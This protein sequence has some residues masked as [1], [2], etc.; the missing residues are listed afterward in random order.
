VRRSIF[1]PAFTLI[2]LLVVIAIIAVLIGMLI[3]AVQKVRMAALSTQCKNNLKQI[4][5]AITMYCQDNG[6]R[7]PT[8]THLTG[9]PKD[10]WVFKIAP[11]VEN[12]DKIR[13]CPVD[14][15]GEQ[16]LH[17]ADP[18][19][20]RGTSYVLNDYLVLRQP[21][22][23]LYMQYLPATS[24]TITVYTISD[25]QGLSVVQDHVHSINWFREPNGVWERLLTDIQPDR[26]GGPQGNIDTNPAHH[27]G[28]YANYLYA[29]G[30]VE[31]IPASQIKQWCDDFFNF[32]VPPP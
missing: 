28:G 31:V 27:T 1:R 19:T 15:F 16:R 9:L 7:F 18:Q 13:I 8:T 4:G 30:H 10:A 25:V 23:I 29:D 12:V 22:A 20:P 14:P 11:Y 2:E 32:S 3:P 24:R 26:F 5:L 21:G 6:G 17:P